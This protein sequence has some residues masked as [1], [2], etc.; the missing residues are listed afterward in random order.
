MS[1]EEDILQNLPSSLLD[2]H[3]VPLVKRDVVKVQ[4]KFFFL[5]EKKFFLKGVS[6]GPFSP[7]THGA[8]FPE[9]QVVEKDFG[10][11]AE[12]GANC[13]R[14]YHIPPDWLL[15][16]AAAYGLRMLIGIPWAQHV[17][18][19]DSP[20]LQQEIRQ[21]IA[22]GVKACRSHP[23]AFAYVVG[24][25][26]PPDIVRWYG[27]E[28]I[29]AFVKELMAV[30]KESDPE[31]LVSYANYPCTEYLNINFTDF[32]CFN[33]YLHR[34][35]DFRR[36]LSR[37]HNLSDDKPLVLSEFG[38]D[39]IREGTE[40]Q[41]EILSQKLSSSFE[42]GAAGT[43]VF[44]WTDEW[45]TGGFAVQDW[46]FGLVDQERLKKPAFQMVQQYYKAVLPPM[47]PEYPKVSVV[48]C[49]Y[50]AERTMD[51]CLASLKKLNYPNYEVIV[52]N[53][54]STDRTLEITQRYDYARLIS[55][56]NKGLSAARNVGIAAATG[57]IVAF[58]DSDCV[59][60]PDWLTYLVG[61]FLSS[62]VSAVGG[63]NLPPP[64]DSLV[65]ACVA[66][67]PGAPVHVL[68]SDEVAEHI[69]GC[70]MAFRREALLEIDGFDPVFHA[71]GDDVDLCWRLQDKGYIISF[72]PAALVWHFRRNTVKDYL[73]QQRGYGKAEALLYF[74]HPYRF[75]LL[76]QPCWSGRIYGDLSAVVL[77]QPMIYSGVF[78][79]G[80]F[81]TLY[82][83]PASLLSYL[84]LTLEWNVAAAIL[85]V[86]ALL[87][88][89]YLWVG[90]AL[91]VTSFIW[92]VSGAR[93]APIE[94]CFRGVKA[95]LLVAQL[96]YLG[97]LVRSIER[98]R[99]RTRILTKVVPI[100][101]ADY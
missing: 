74:K 41:A 25:E 24:N 35:K 36:Y 27:P 28:R 60:D 85:F 31:A 83:S 12:L 47:L 59:A 20:S 10:L 18:F 68:L 22:H 37:L 84:P 8:P 39:S 76:G 80:L 55:Q 23:A 75:N 77:R 17:C 96:I 97:P 5:G 69:A 72:S 2:F 66:V 100:K 78:G 4:G 43:V 91:F 65:P 34:E 48:V 29:R 64:E 16:L 90:G 44:S 52:V 93:R 56:E 30:A 54:G 88:G 87:S 9:R 58:T 51:S 89:H 94:P 61:K 95:R 32:V 101:F 13:L 70:N 63:P 81:Q 11:I 46:A 92:C 98:Y 14:T 7:A 26:I 73:K 49:A 33:V 45:F 86:S 1:Y 40:A 21:A 42:M 53:D 15:D 57:E 99:W 3:P 82:Q 38:V 50:N 71:A 62:G 19:L 79:Q 6:Y 67:S